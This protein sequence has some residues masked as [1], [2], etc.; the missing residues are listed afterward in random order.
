MPGM[1]AEFKKKFN[2]YCRRSGWKHKELAKELHVDA[3]T[4]SKWVNGHNP[5][6]VDSLTM[7]CELLELN[8]DEKQELF[9]LAGLEE[10]T[11]IS[12]QAK[13]QDKGPVPH[14]PLQRPPRVLHFTGREAEIEQILED[15]QPEQIVT[16]V[17]PGGIGKTALAVEA[18]WALAPNDAPPA[19]FPDGIIFYEFY[20]HPQAEQALEHIAASLGEKPQPGAA[21]AAA[22]R[23]LESR[24]VLLVLDGAEN[25]DNLGAVLRVRGSQCGVLITT[26]HYHDAEGPY[27][28]VDTLPPD[29]ARVL[30]H[31]WSQGKVTDRTIGDQICALVGYLPLALRLAGQ[32]MAQRALHAAEYLEL[33]KETELAALHLDDRKHKSI[34][35]L[36]TLSIEP[37]NDQDRQI[38]AVVGWLPLAPFTPATIAAALATSTAH[39]FLY[40]GELTD[41]SLIKRVDPHYEVTH[42]LIYTYVRQELNASPTLLKR[43][44]DHYLTF[45]RSQQAQGIEGYAALDV[46]R[47]HLMDVLVKCESQQE[48][49]RVKDLVWAIDEYLDLQGHWTQRYLALQAG[50]AAARA[51]NSAYDEGRFLNMLGDLH[52]QQSRWDKALQLCQESLLIF[53]KSQDQPGEAQAFNTIGLISFDQSQWGVAI[54]HF[55]GSLHIRQ[56]LEDRRGQAQVHNHL[57]EVY[58]QLSRWD[59]AIQQAKKALYIFRE[60]GDQV[61]ESKALNNLGN[62]YADQGHKSKAIEMYQAS[63]L[64]QKTLGDRLSEANALHNR[65]MIYQDQGQWNKAS[66]SYQQA[67]AIYRELGARLRERIT[68]T[69]LGDLYA[70]QADF[71]QA[72]KAYKESLQIAQALHDRRGEAQ[73]L[74]NLGIVYADQGRWDEALKVYEQSLQIKRELHDY[75]GE[76]HSLN[77]LGR[78][79]A[80][81]G[82]IDE[83]IKL[84]EDSLQITRGLNNREGEAWALESRALV[85]TKQNKWLK[86]IEK[87]E[88]ALILFREVGPQLWVGKTLVGLTTAYTTLNRFAEAKAA[89][90]EALDLFRELKS[91]HD[92]GIALMRLG[93]FHEKQGDQEQAFD[94]WEQALPLVHPESPDHKLLTQKLQQKG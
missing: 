86:A 32:Y 38:L 49:T 60:R 20:G 56:E 87:Y 26:T 3:S 92:E 70:D 54:Q 9:V 34:S 47:P 82:A 85:Y 55:E 30:L 79:K 8:K 90:E 25:A 11:V 62:I 83:A 65:A 94:F 59:L 29:K 63:L 40:L 6:P 42:R 74:N 36:L 76:G 88:E 22:G 2:Y 57:A 44:A 80:E 27:R 5:W 24:Q 37:L 23:L 31:H 4:L 16:L 72:I 66:T 43:L 53:Q 93:F 77:N 84:L 13:P 15:L 73:T 28:Q 7:A 21:R 33:L 48:W 68:L 50:L 67:L 35:V 89:I 18:I 78:V 12:D 71:T 69:G 81:Q 51:L 64:L 10:S 91:Q 58:R 1:P 41:N 61:D 14:V 39:T 52:R 17:G 45:A 19:R 46:E 75:L